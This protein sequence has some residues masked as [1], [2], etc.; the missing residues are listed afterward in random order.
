VRELDLEKHVRFTGYVEDEHLPALISL[1]EVMVYPSLH[2]GF[3]FPVLEALACGTPVVTAR[4]SSLPEAGGQAARYVNDAMDA[5]ALTEE[6]Y[7][8][9]HDQ[10]E[11]ARM[12]RAGLEHAS[13]FTWEATARR[14]MELYTEV[15][16]AQ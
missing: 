6:L 3:G 5:T 13:T 10:G 12:I 15:L 2:E 9:L 11:R 8:V 4:N 7:I 1:A 14:V 16:A